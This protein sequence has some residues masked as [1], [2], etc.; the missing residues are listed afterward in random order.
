MKEKD[1][2]VKKLEN[3][4]DKNFVE[5]KELKDKNLIFGVHIGKLI[6]TNKLLLQKNS[7]LKVKT[8]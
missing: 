4:I 8:I 2:I 6:E 1:F 5:I 7:I 3:E